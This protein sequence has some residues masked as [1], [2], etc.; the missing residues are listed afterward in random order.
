MWVIIARLPQGKITPSQQA[1]DSYVASDDDEREELYCD[2]HHVA[3]V[4]GDFLRIIGQS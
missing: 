2:F 3:Y 1:M 4:A